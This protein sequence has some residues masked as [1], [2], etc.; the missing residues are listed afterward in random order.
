VEIAVPSEL[1]PKE[2]AAI[3]ALNEVT[4]WSPR[5]EEQQED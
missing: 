1:N 3:E 4:D 2:R 5:N